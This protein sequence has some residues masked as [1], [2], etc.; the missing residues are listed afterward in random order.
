MM[1][2]KKNWDRFLSFGCAVMMIYCHMLKPRLLV[3]AAVE[4]SSED[5]GRESSHSRAHDRHSW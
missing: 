3:G 1:Q 4:G 2:K 5:S